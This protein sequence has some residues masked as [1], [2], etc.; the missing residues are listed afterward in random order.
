M[1]SEH[2]SAHETDPAEPPAEADAS[3]PS[4][5]SATGEPVAAEA[6]TAP[7]DAATP[8]DPAA[9]G[10]RGP[11][12][13]AI[14]DAIPSALDPLRSNDP[15]VTMRGLQA[16][17]NDPGDAE[18]GASRHAEV[19]CQSLTI[20]P[21]LQHAA[22]AY[23]EGELVGYQAPGGHPEGHSD[24]YEEP[25]DEG[26][27]AGVPYVEGAGSRAASQGDAGTSGDSGQ[28]PWGGAEPQGSSAPSQRE[29]AE[30]QGSSA[31]PQDDTAESRV[32]PLAWPDAEPLAAEAASAPPWSNGEEFRGQ[33]SFDGPF[34]HSADLQPANAGTQPSAIRGVALALPLVI[35]RGPDADGSPLVEGRRVNLSSQA[36]PLPTLMGSGSEPSQQ[37][38]VA[39]QPQPGV[40]GA[41]GGERLSADDT[42]SPSGEHGAVPPAPAS[43]AEG[44]P[45]AAV[46]R[47]TTVASA[48]QAPLTSQD[49]VRVAPPRSWWPWALSAA[50]VVAVVGAVGASVLG[51]M[52]PSPP[53]A[54]APASADGAHSRVFA[55]SREPRQGAPQGAASS[56][57][58]VQP[59]ATPSA[60][61]SEDC[62]AKDTGVD[63]R[64]AACT[65]AD[66][67]CS[68]RCEVGAGARGSTAASPSPAPSS[69]AEGA[70]APATAPPT[71]ETSL[72]P[73]APAHPLR[74]PAVQRVSPY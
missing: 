40:T 1:S 33:L 71:D 45:P 9:V 48:Q 31:P 50:A 66:S 74:D 29:G 18:R 24:A 14:R 20:P 26:D 58:P 55:A 47:L 56:A 10:S 25:A 28:P 63:I 16:P 6:P 38:A 60:C 41:I 44:S 57:A 22:E 23:A 42:L 15:S 2:P 27:A 54:N 53:A 51:L 43:Q 37:L 7:D 17:P 64:C 49:R 8:E 11:A 12:E 35:A 39:G 5:A 46:D 3:E 36:P 68:A 72:A 59:P 30:P 67:T 61:G 13:G 52:A 69:P 70:R 73:R 34:V 62:P 32:E 4:L 19:D 21:W 65:A